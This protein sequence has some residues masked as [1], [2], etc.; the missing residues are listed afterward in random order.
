MAMAAM[1]M[2]SAGGFSGVSFLLRRCPLVVASVLCKKTPIFGSQG[3]KLDHLTVCIG[4]KSFSSSHERCG[5]KRL[6]R[7]NQQPVYYNYEGQDVHIRVEGRR[8]RERE[9]MGGSWWS[10][11]AIKGRIRARGYDDEGPRRASENNNA[12]CSC[13]PRRS[14]PA[15]PV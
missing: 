12:A 1:N 11:Y 14:A 3:S 15:A 6:T 10:I 7:L 9:R 8:E 13:A 5:R 4:Y 2:V